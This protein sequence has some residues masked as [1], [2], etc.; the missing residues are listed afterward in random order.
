MSQGR[1][2]KAKRW[3]GGLSRCQ[4]LNEGHKGMANYTVYCSHVL[5]G[6]LSLVGVITW[7]TQA[8]TREESVYGRECSIVTAVIYL[9][10]VGLPRDL[11]PDRRGM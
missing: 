6:R 8:L 10:A 2:V 3:V 11:E 4:R 7:A 5:W 9:N 1:R